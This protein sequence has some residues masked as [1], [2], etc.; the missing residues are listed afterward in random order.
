MAEAAEECGKKFPDFPKQTHAWYFRD[1]AAK[2]IYT[3]IF[4]SL[5][6]YVAEL[7]WGFRNWWIFDLLWI[8]DWI[9]TITFLPLAVF[10]FEALIFRGFKGTNFG[11]VCACRVHVCPLKF[12]LE[13][14]GWVNF[15]SFIF[16]TEFDYWN[17]SVLGDW[18]GKFL[19]SV[20]SSQI[21]FSFFCHSHAS[22]LSR[23]LNHDIKIKTFKNQESCEKAKLGF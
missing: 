13:S 1:T 5:L 3:F 20:L 14:I 22:V 17:Y 18:A 4:F 2:K 9:A 6:C 21:S 23:Y 8:M 12:E 11:L 7:N 19:F 15:R 16:V 10:A